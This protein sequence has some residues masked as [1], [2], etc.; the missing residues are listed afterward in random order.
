LPDKETVEK[1]DDNLDFQRGVQAFTA[2]SVASKAPIS[3]LRR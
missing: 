1:V 2:M 3:R